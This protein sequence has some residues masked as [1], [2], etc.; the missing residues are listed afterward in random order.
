MIEAFTQFK[1]WMQGKLISPYLQATFYRAVI[2]GSSVQ[3]NSDIVNF[4]LRKYEDAKKSRFQRV[5]YFN[6]LYDAY[7]HYHMAKLTSDMPKSIK[8]EICSMATKYYFENPVLGIKFLK[9]CWYKLQKSDYALDIIR[10]LISNVG[11]KRQIKEL[12]KWAKEENVT[13]DIMEGLK[14]LTAMTTMKLK[15]ANMIAS[16]LAKDLPEK[17][18]SLKSTCQLDNVKS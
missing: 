10:M 13:E 6:Q 3:G 16:V 8:D 5:D 18:I 4:L 1:G 12:M 2:D 14:E 11:S 9:I 17:T 15:C 7:I